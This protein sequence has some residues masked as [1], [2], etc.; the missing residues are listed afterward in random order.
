MKNLAKI[1]YFVICNKTTCKKFPEYSKLKTFYKIQ[2]K[3]KFQN[4]ITTP[5]SPLTLINHENH[6]SQ[7]KLH[8]YFVVNY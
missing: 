7:L 5:A 4:C 3:I 6:S 2:R 8:F 1:K